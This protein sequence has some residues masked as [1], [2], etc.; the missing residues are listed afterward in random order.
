MAMPGT[1]SASTVKIGV[2]D[3]G[4]AVS[5][6][7]RA[8]NDKDVNTRPTFYRGAIGAAVAALVVATQSQRSRFRENFL[9]AAPS[10]RSGRAKSAVI[11]ARF[12]R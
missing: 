12:S 3:S 8:I 9:A 5:R 1:S 6:W 11:S 2:V 7:S 4:P 10:R